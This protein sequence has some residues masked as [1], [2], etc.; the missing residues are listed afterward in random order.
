MKAQVL[1]ELICR[2]N[3]FGETALML[4]ASRGLNPVCKALLDNGAGIEGTNREGWTALHFAAS[5][6]RTGVVS[7]LLQRGASVNARNREGYTG[8]H[9]ACSKNVCQTIPCVRCPS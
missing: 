3:K 6:G 8:L 1:A 7:L 2:K 4:A 5:A 9:Y